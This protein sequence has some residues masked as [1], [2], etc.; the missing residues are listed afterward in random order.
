MV[1]WGSWDSNPGWPDS[2]DILSITLHGLQRGQRTSHIITLLNGSPPS[3]LMGTAKSELVKKSCPS[4]SNSL[5]SED[6]KSLWT[7]Q[8]QGQGFCVDLVNTG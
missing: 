7:K 3:S 5:K 2:E 6:P 4:S 8:F 1:G